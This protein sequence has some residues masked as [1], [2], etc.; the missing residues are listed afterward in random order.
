MKSEMKRSYIKFISLLLLLSWSL[1]GCAGQKP[2]A[3]FRDKWVERYGTSQNISVLF[4]TA[5]ELTQWAEAIA[6]LDAEVMAQIASYT[7]EYFGEHMLVVV[8]YMTAGALTISAV[9]D[10]GVEVVVKLKQKPVPGQTAD[11]DVRP[12]LF[13]ITMPRNDEAIRARYTV[14]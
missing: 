2:D 10:T 8:Y 4:Q 5:D 3:V 6:E 1:C 9:E 7:P 11:G 12:Y 14:V 13:F